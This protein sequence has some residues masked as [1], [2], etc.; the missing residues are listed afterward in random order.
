MKQWLFNLLA[1]VSLLLSLTAAAAWA[2]SYTQTPDWHLLG[3]AHS[4]DLRRVDLNQRTGIVMMPVAGSNLARS[5][6]RCGHGV[7]PGD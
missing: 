2:M 1:V 6:T 4:A 3:M 5:G 7:G